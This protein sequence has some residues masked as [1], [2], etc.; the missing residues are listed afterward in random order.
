LPSEIS[1]Q[2]PPNLSPVRELLDCGIDDLGGVSPVTDDHINPDY[3]WPAIEELQTIANEAG[4]PLIERLPV[5]ERYLPNDQ[6]PNKWVSKEIMDV[7]SGDSEVESRYQKVRSQDP[8][9]DGA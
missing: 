5:Y 9:I 4:V 7:I 3:A 8:I 6:S 2:V 1:V